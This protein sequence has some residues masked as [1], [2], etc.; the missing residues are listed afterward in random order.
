MGLAGNAT[1]APQTGSARTANW[2]SRYGS[3]AVI[4]EMAARRHR[5][6]VPEGRI[7]SFVLRQG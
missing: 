4:E 6:S 1:I 7:G 5:M 3:P 2:E